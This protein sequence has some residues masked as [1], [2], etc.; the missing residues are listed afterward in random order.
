M[1]RSAKMLAED[2]KYEGDINKIKEYHNTV[3]LTNNLLEDK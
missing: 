2:T 1:N 3:D